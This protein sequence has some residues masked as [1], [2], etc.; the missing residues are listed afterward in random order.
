MGSKTKRGI[1]SGIP[2][3]LWGREELLEQGQPLSWVTP[4]EVP[5]APVP[6]TL[7]RAEI[8]RSSASAPW[9]SGQCPARDVSAVNRWD[10]AG[11]Q[12][13]EGGPVC[14]CSPAS[15]TP[16][17]DPGWTMNIHE[18]EIIQHFHKTN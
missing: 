12:Q 5:A 3:S 17:G 10:P 7:R 16:A 11:V 4:R 2:R 9:A 15:P 13:E 1:H 14:E 6:P 8:R 18:V